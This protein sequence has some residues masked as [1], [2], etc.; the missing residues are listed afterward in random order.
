MP[1]GGPL[2][3]P[4][5]VRVPRGS[6]SRSSSPVLGSPLAA[7]WTRPTCAAPSGGWSGLGTLSAGP[8]VRASTPTASF[9]HR[10]RVQWTPLDYEKLWGPTLRFC[11]NKRKVGPCATR[12]GDSA[13]TERPKPLLRRPLHNSPRVTILL[14]MR[15]RAWLQLRRILS[16]AAALALLSSV[17]ETLVPET[18][19]G[20]VAVTSIQITSTPAPDQPTRAPNHNP[21]SPHICHCVHAHLAALSTDRPL[22]QLIEAHVAV[23][24][25][26]HRPPPAPPAAF[27]FRPPIA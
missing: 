26:R 4:R 15:Q 18:H 11:R 17:G 24:A 23:P 6:S 16:V 13:G 20:D 21:D 8:S 12:Q 3:I 25:F 5:R 10:G 22:V 27:H 9:W 2:G 1:P 19:D 7:G 14:A